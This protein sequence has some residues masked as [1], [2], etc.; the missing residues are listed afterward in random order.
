[1]KK[2]LLISAA[3][4]ATAPL[5]T[6]ASSDDSRHGYDDCKRYGTGVVASGSTSTGGTST[7]CV[8]KP[9]M[10]GAKDELHGLQ[11]ALGKLSPADRAEL[12]KMIRTYL[13][14]KGVALPTEPVKEIK[15]E[16]K[17]ER[18]EIKQDRKE[19]LKKMKERR[20]ALREKMKELRK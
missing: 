4:I 13:A 7:G 16:I 18:K 11:L 9:Y 14:S 1:M 19:Y 3:L 20:E 12:V 6:L 15:K 5:L 10:T 2:I 17:K 8:N